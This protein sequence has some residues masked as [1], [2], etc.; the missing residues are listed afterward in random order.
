MDAF[1]YGCPKKALCQ[2]SDGAMLVALLAT[3]PTPIA[4]GRRYA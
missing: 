2:E 4:A 3:V 1:A